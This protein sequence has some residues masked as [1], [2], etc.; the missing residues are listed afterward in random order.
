MKKNVFKLKLEDHTICGWIRKPDKSVCR[1]VPLAIFMHGVTLDKDS[2]PLAELS[3]HLI[4][5]EIAVLSFDFYGHGETGGS[6]DKMSVSR[7]VED[8]ESVLSYVESLWFVSEIFLVGHSQGGVTASIVAGRHPLEVQAM[9]LYAP[10]AV[11]ED[12]SKTGELPGFTFNPADIPEKVP[13]FAGYLG[14]TYFRSAQKL[15]VYETAEQ[16]NGP[17]IILHGT[18]DQLVPVPYAWKYHSIYEGSRLVLFDKEDHM[19]HNYRE[20]AAQEVTAF[21][22]YKSGRNAGTSG[23]L[24]A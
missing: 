20:K 18:D 17:V 21:L 11:I 19:F 4:D 2:M 24:R 3:G 12:I 6:W 22:L 16:Y 23:R 8:A 10:A 15:R 5:S 14:R 1:K 7:W 9:A 13:F